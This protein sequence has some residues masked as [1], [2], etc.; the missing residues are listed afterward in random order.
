M[1]MTV[2]PPIPWRSAAWMF[3][4]FVFSAC[5]PRD[6]QIAAQATAAAQA[7]DSSVTIQVTG[8]VAT[9]AGQLK[10]RATQLAV[11][12]AVHQV[13]GVE[14][15]SDETTIE[16]TAQQP[17]APPQVLSADDQ[18]K[19]R[20]DSCFEAGNLPGIRVEVSAGEVTLTGS[21]KTDDLNKMMQIVQDAKPQKIINQV[22][23]DDSTRKDSAQ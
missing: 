21:A 6:T 20:I 11:E 3:V 12:A 14:R 18:L 8:G 13:K 4:C 7:V 1:H 5:G 2:T 15:V 10:D 23:I 22:S 16:D 9:I 17:V 19:H